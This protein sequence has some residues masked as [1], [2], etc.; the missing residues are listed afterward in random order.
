MEKK[1][2]N[3]MMEGIEAKY[4]DIKFTTLIELSKHFDDA[5]TRLSFDEA[6]QV[7]D[8]INGEVYGLIGRNMDTHNA[9]KAG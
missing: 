3:D 2:F 9:N 4:H 8:Q 6:K 7:A 5:Y 1:Q